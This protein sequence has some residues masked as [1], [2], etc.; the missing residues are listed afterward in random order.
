MRPSISM[1]LLIG[2]LIAAGPAKDDEAKKDLAALQGTWALESAE[3]DGKKVP[4]EEVKNTRLIVEGNKFRFSK[5]SKV[6]T[7]QEGTFVLD[8]TKSPKATASTATVGPDKGKEFL[9]IYEIDGDKHTVCL[10]PPGKERPKALSSK[11]GSGHFLQV[12]KRVK[13]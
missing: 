4:E 12:W 9:G 5:D 1:I 6:G 11:P 2:L 8:P 3:K 10:A 7:S 13:N